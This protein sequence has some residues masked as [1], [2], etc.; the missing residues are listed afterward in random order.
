MLCEINTGGGRRHSKLP[1]RFSIKLLRKNQIWR[2]PCGGSIIPNASQQNT[3]AP[4]V[5]KCWPAKRE[6]VTYRQ[7]L[8]SRARKR[9]VSSSAL[10]PARSRGVS[11]S[12][13][14][15]KVS[16]LGDPVSG[17]TR[18]WRHRLTIPSPPNV[19]QQSTRAKA[20]PKLTEQSSRCVAL[21]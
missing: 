15:R 21:R 5:A 1:C 3:R 19:S 10:G 2:T 6:S 20:R 13:S 8:A 9:N 16:G 14:S 11:L 7:M 4:R 12:N 17:R 18:D